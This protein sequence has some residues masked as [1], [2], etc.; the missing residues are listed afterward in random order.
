M[1]EEDLA[2]K[3]ASEKR[4]YDAAVKAAASEVSDK[5]VDLGVR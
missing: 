4:E 1:L 2:D 3:I 5:D